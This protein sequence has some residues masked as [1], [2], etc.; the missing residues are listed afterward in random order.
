MKHKPSSH[1]T[2]RSSELAINHKHFLELL[3]LPLAI[4]GFAAF[5]LLLEW[6]L[7]W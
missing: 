3:S 7:K 4:A 2:E 1:K 5:V 6:G